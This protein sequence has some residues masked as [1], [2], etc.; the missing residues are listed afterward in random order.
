MSALVIR[1]AT[2]MDAPALAPLISELGYPADAALAGERLALLQAAGDEALVA[3][4]GSDLVGLAA[5]H[6]TPLL[7]RPGPLGRITALV[8]SAS[9][10]RQ[11]IGRALV[12]VAEAR[13][14]ERGCVRIELTSNLQRKEAHAFYWALG[15]VDDGLRFSRTL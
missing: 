5:L 7:H 15:Y 6:L 14:A 8:A 2:P 9:A 4:R 11:G 3:L 13:L 1:T 10:R 12:Q